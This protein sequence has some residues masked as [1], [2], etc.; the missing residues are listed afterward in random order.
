MLEY[1]Q[2]E[3]DDDGRDDRDPLTNRGGWAAMFTPGN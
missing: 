3:G 2:E 1:V